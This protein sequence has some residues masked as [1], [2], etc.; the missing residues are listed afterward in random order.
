MPTLATAATG[1]RLVLGT[2]AIPEITN[3]S[4][5]GAQFEVVDV[6]A[7]DG[8]NWASKIPTLLD[9]GTIRVEANLV[10]GNGTHVALGTAMMNRQSSAFRVV[11]P[12]VGNPPWT[13]NAFVT[14]WRMPSTPVRGALPLAFD[15]TVDGQINFA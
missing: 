8:G 7:H 11:L 12:T 1:I 15:L 4:D 6:S 2:T 5:I 10:P 13:F 14:S 3:I 9:G